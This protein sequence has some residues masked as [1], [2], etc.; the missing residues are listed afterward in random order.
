MLSR[1]LHRCGWWELVRVRMAALAMFESETDR[2]GI[3]PNLLFSEAPNAVI[4]GPN[5]NSRKL[6]WKGAGRAEHLFPAKMWK[7]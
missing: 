3:G 6:T 4:R 7:P 1:L 2:S 5:A